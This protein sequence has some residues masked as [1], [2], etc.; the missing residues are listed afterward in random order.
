MTLQ[1]WTTN[2]NLK[3]WRKLTRRD[4]G[5]SE[6]MM[7]DEKSNDWRGSIQK[8]TL[9]GLTRVNWTPFGA[10]WWLIGCFQWSSNDDSFW[11]TAVTNDVVN[12]KQQGAGQKLM[13]GWHK[14]QGVSET[15]KNADVISEQPLGGNIRS[16]LGRLFFS[17]RGCSQKT[18]AF[19]RVSYTPWCLCQ[20]IISFWPASWCFKLITSVEP[21]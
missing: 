15:P 6:K 2:G 9:V 7:N 8:R 3:S 11:L 20:P 1:H 18:S 21:S 5:S 19:F 4:Q 17:I 12:L 10:N 13:I 16:L 14:H